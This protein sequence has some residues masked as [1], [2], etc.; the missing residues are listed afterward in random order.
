M[1]WVPLFLAG[2]TTAFAEIDP[3]SLQVRLCTVQELFD[4]KEVVFHVS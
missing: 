4:Q 1:E 3:V 2:N